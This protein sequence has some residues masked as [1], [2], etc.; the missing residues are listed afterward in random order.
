MSGKGKRSKM[1]WKLPLESAAELSVVIQVYFHG[2]ESLPCLFS[3][4]LS[5]QGTFLPPIFC[6]PA[7]D[8][9]SSPFQYV[10]EECNSC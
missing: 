5:R 6:I 3:Y 9:I 8:S 1:A 4:D 2:M 7:L 10:L